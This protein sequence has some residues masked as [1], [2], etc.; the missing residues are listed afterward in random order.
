MIGTR[1]YNV[2]AANDSTVTKIPFRLS[3]VRRFITTT[4]RSRRKPK[5]TPLSEPATRSDRRILFSRQRCSC[6]SPGYWRSWVHADRADC[7][8]LVCRSFAGCAPARVATSTADCPG[9]G[10]RKSAPCPRRRP[11]SRAR[12]RWIACTPSPP[13]YLNQGNQVFHQLAPIHFS[14]R[15]ELSNSNDNNNNN[16]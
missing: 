9:S 16:I 14:T 2:D 15:N 8:R 13:V 12:S 10:N 4:T 6:T 1:I 3:L 7:A 5:I 11:S